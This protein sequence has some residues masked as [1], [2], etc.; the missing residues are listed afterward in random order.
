MRVN[1]STAPRHS[2]GRDGI[3]IGERH[4]IHCRAGFAAGI[5]FSAQSGI[6]ES[7]R[8]A[9][10]RL[11]GVS[12]DAVL[13]LEAHSALGHYWVLELSGRLRGYLPPAAE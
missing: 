3:V 4:E 9:H 2:P 8:N 7:K 11:S 13:E 12:G 5:C 10:T 1:T 6:C